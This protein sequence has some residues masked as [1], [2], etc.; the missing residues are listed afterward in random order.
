MVCSYGL[1]DRADTLRSADKQCRLVDRSLPVCDFVI[2]NMSETYTVSYMCG[3]VYTNNME[4]IDVPG[5]G[6]C[7]F[8][9][10]TRDS[11]VSFVTGH[12]VKSHIIRTLMDEQ[13]RYSRLIE[14]YANCSVDAYVKSVSPPGHYAVETMQLV[15]VAVLRLDIIE[16]NSIG[17][18]KRSLFLLVDSNQPEI[19]KLSM[20]FE[21]WAQVAILHHEFGRPAPFEFPTQQQK[22]EYIRTLNSASWTL[23]ISSPPE[24]VEVPTI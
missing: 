8:H 18:M 5:D 16:F 1:E 9:A 4:F 22:Q 6:K 3:D 10:L 24:S 19:F 12:E 17:E 15:A 14:R 21:N 20:G 13:A 7:F 11:A 2:L 23:W